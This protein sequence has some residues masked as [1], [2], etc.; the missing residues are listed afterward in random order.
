[1]IYCHECN[2]VFV[3]KMRQSK[4]EAKDFFFHLC[5]VTRCRF[6]SM[7]IIMHYYWGRGG[8]DSWKKNHGKKVEFFNFSVIVYALHNGGKIFLKSFLHIIVSK[9]IKSVFYLHWKHLMTWL[10]SCDH[11]GCNFFILISLGLILLKPEVCIQL[12]LFEFSQS[13]I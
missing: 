3:F 13:L 9:F 10:N 4:H 7:H 11:W 5:K 8:R 1:M 6:L 12:F 2:M